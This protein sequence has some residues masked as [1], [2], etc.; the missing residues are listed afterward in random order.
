[1]RV[2]NRNCTQLDSSQE[3]PKKKIKAA[4]LFR[5]RC[6]FLLWG[7]CASERRGGSC[8]RKEK[9]PARH[10]RTALKGKI[11]ITILALESTSEFLAAIRKC[12]RDAIFGTAFIIEN[13]M[14]F[15]RRKKKIVCKN[16]SRE[17]IGVRVLVP[18]QFSTFASLRCGLREWKTFSQ[19]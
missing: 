5:R 8:V 17:T 7:A 11:K 9:L 4:I 10:R 2:S 18:A 19:E 13:L 14:N 1:M 3:K 6:I 15:P 16:P 12:F